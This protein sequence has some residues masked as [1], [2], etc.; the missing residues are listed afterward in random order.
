M[1]QPV[2]RRWTF[3][4]SVV[5][6]TDSSSS[7]GAPLVAWRWDFGDGEVGWGTPVTHSYGA[8]GSFTVTLAITDVCGFGQSLLVERALAVY[9]GYNVYLPTVLRNY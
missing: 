2:A 9:T 8:P 6:F 4:L 1:A 3:T 7:N 5:T